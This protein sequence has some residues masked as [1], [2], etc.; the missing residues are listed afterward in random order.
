MAFIASSRDSLTRLTVSSS[1]ALHD[2]GRPATSS[3]PP[4]PSSHDGSAELR[5]GRIPE[6]Q[7]ASTDCP[8]LRRGFLFLVTFKDD[9]STWITR[10]WTAS[11]PPSFK[12]RTAVKC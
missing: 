3:P 6:S 2:F 7:Y 9:V 8:A 1:L 11:C 5:L 12:T 10:N 4:S